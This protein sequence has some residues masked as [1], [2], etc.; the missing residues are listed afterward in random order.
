MTS[1]G[2]I[3]RET[4]EKPGQQRPLSRKHQPIEIRDTKSIGGQLIGLK[5]F[6]I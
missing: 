3:L 1:F 4:E 2:Q 6:I 5:N